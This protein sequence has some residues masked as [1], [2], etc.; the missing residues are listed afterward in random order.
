[1]G[2]NG[3]VISHSSEFRKRRAINWVTLGVTYSAMYMARYNLSLALPYLQRVFGW[4][5]TQM[6]TIISVAAAVYGFGAILN[7]PLGDKLG[8]RKSMIIGASG[9]VVFNTLFGL[10]AYL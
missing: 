4:D 1:M 8:G 2:G 3:T 10:A 7:G 6:G 9:A 5:K